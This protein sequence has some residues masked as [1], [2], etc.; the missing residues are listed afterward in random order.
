MA[1]TIEIASGAIIANEALVKANLM[2]VGQVQTMDDNRRYIVLKY[3]VEGFDHLIGKTF[4]EDQSKTAFEA[5][6]IALSYERKLN[7]ALE[8]DSPTEPI[9][10]L[11]PMVDQLQTA[12]FYVYDIEVKTVV[13]NPWKETMTLDDLAKGRKGE[14]LTTR[15]VKVDLESETGFS[16]SEAPVENTS[17]RMP[18]GEMEDEQSLLKAL[19]RFGKIAKKA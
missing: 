16:V 15:T 6:K 8:N 12:N 14:V 2:E 7:S 1:K 13:F 9:E 18:S 3:A 11:K 10:R 17:F 5:A 19:A 4:F